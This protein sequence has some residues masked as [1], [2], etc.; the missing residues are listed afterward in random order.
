MKLEKFNLEK[1]IHGAKVVTRDGLEV[2]QLTKFEGVTTESHSLVGV[3]RG[4]IYS[5]TDEGE[6]DGVFSRQPGRDLFLA[7]EPQGT[8]VNVY[9]R[10][11]ALEFG[12][13]H[14]TEKEALMY[15]ENL[16]NYIKTIE[17]TDKL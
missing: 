8:W 10:D 6:F 15:A 7:V 4:R 2:T 12:V 16:K 1:A 17:I 5:W 3:L 13:A 9:T 14:K 11:G